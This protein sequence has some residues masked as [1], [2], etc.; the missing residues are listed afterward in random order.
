[1]G[2]FLVLAQ[3]W[4]GKFKAHTSHLLQKQFLAT[5]LR[6]GWRWGGKPGCRRRNDCATEAVTQSNVSLTWPRREHRRDPHS[7]LSLGCVQASRSR[8]IPASHPV[9]APY[10]MFKCSDAPM[11]FLAM[12]SHLQAFKE[13]G[14]AES[15]RDYS[16]NLWQTKPTCT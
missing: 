11:H 2:H 8:R 14:G 9:T 12:C 4:P 6:M 5:R 3:S 13:V 15:E 1:M 7:Q 10:G 16:C